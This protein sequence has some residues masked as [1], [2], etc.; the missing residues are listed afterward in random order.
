MKKLFTLLL[1][2][3][4]SLGALAYDNPN[5]FSGVS[6]KDIGSDTQ[7][8][9]ITTAGSLAAWKEADT[10][11]SQQG[12]FNSN[13]ARTKLV[14]TGS[15]T[16]ADFDVITGWNKFTFAD[17]SSV[18]GV[19]P[20]DISG[21]NLSNATTIVLPN[22]WTEEQVKTAGGI[23]TSDGKNGNLGTA[24]SKNPYVKP[25]ST[26][27]YY[28][29]KDGQNVTYNGTVT[30]GQ[31]TVTINEPV[32]IT[33]LTNASGYPKSTYTNT[34]FNNT[35]VEVEPSEG[36]TSWI[37]NPLDVALNA[38]SEYTYN[39][40]VLN[41]PQIVENN[42]NYYMDNNW[43]RWNS[44]LNLG[45]QPDQWGNSV[46]YDQ[47]D[48]HLL[49][50]AKITYNIQNNNQLYGVYVNGV[51]QEGSGPL[52]TSNGTVYGQIANEGEN[53]VSFPI[54]SLYKYTYTLDGNDIETQEFTSAQTQI[55]T[56]HDV[57]Y[58]LLSNEVTE[59]FNLTKIFAYV[60]V[61]GTFDDAVNVA[62]ITKSTVD[63][64]ALI[65]GIN[66]D[67]LA[68]L[69]KNNY[70]NVEY[71][72]MKDAVLTG[73]ITTLNAR[74]EAAIL[75]PQINDN[76]TTRHITDAEL[77]KLQ[78]KNITS[79]NEQYFHCLAYFKS[80]DASK[81]ESKQLN[82][83]AFDNA[84]GK[85]SNVVKA[86][87]NIAITFIPR[88]TEDGDFFNIYGG[89]VRGFVGYQFTSSSDFNSLKEGIGQL[90][91][92]SIDMEIISNNMWPDFTFLNAN[93]HYIQVHGNVNQNNSNKYDNRFDISSESSSRYVYPNTVWVVSTYKVDES[94]AYVLDEN[95]NPVVIGQDPQGKDIW[96]RTGYGTYSH[97][98]GERFFEAQEPTNIVY[99]RDRSKLEGCDE[100]PSLL[101]EAKKYFE[102]DQMFA[103]QQIFIGSYN[104]ADIAAIND[105]FA[106]T[107]IDFVSASSF[108]QVDGKDCVAN[109]TNSKVQYLLLPDNHESVINATSADACAFSTN[110]T[111]LLCVGAYNET[112]NRLTTWSRQA[113][114]VAN[115]TSKL[116][117]K[118]G[119]HHYGTIYDNYCQGL[120]KVT[121]SGVLNR[122][123]L[124]NDKGKGLLGSSIQEA[125]FTNAYFPTYTDMVFSMD[126]TSTVA[127]G[128][129]WGGITKLSLPI[130][131]R[132]DR[133]PAHCLDGAESLSELC[134]PYNF[135]YIEESAFNLM[136]ADKITTTDAEGNVIDNGTNTFTLSANLKDIATLAFNT[137]NSALTDV[138]V[139]ATEAPH[140]APFAFT[141]ENYFC[142][143]GFDGNFK[144]P[145]CRDGYQQSEKFY[146]ILHF[147][148]EIS[149]EEAAHYT[150]ITREYSLVDETSAFD[151]QGELLTWPNHT[152]ICRA[153][154]QALSGAL[155]ND[156][157]Y[158]TEAAFNTT[159]GFLDGIMKMKGYNDEEIAEFKEGLTYANSKKSL[160]G[161]KGE[162]YYDLI[163]TY[164][165]SNSAYANQDNFKIGQL[166]EATDY[167]KNSSSFKNYIGWHQFVLSGYSRKINVT[168]KNKDYKKLDFYTLCFPY[169]L[170]REELINL[171]GV[172]AGNTLNGEPVSE[173][174]VLPEV[175]TLKSVI[176]NQVSHRVDLGFSKE[177]MQIADETGKDIT[178]TTETWDYATSDLKTN[179][180]KKGTDKRIFLKG[181]YPYLVKPYVLADVSL[182]GKNLGEYML[183]ISN[184]TP[185]DLGYKQDNI[186]VPYIQGVW[187][188]D[189]KGNKLT[190]KDAENKS[191]NYYYYFQGTYIRQDLP[192][193]AYYLG[194]KSGQRAW[195][196]NTTGTRKWNQ[197]SA[198]IG[199]KCDEESVVYIG[200]NKGDSADGITTPS[201][202]MRN[203]DDA[204]ENNEV[205]V[206]FLFEDEDG[207]DE[208]VAIE[209]INGEAVN[210]AP[211]QGDVYNMTGQ[212]VGNTVEGLAKGLY[213]INGKKILVK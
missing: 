122:D 41:N 183:S 165:R 119:T 30:A 175:Y 177:L 192:Q 56:N 81:P 90:P 156:W 25:V 111:A 97:F 112:D 203:D 132:Q 210:G 93:T 35:V 76:G 20:A 5:G 185:A 53:A 200:L 63:E 34:W 143:T 77:G 64:I 36:Q 40:T 196:Y 206:N 65:N 194:A 207:F 114:V 176:R 27:T 91:A 50:S 70:A 134:I 117:P 169:D 168:P 140:C 154:N 55:Q 71:I 39:G 10:D 100:V 82:I 12:Y 182:T 96:Q 75:L 195:F 19:V 99:V 11:G 105:D 68:E 66:N 86:E 33:E 170:T 48:E 37:P 184:L 118:V 104:A 125:D 21:L 146:A 113:G 45:Q 52:F 109:L 201:V 159:L 181:G 15:M 1:G 171:I 131:S 42:G 179:N 38:T 150:D 79:P 69:S 46:P 205:K 108:E 212:Y 162:N 197:F 129:G 189:E 107:T 149:D 101:A 54:T 8:I 190:W 43:A 60:N 17:F 78:A 84:V 89:S 198:V 7:L 152:E 51:A 186:S 23:L 163:E 94:R 74:G 32:T 141:T 187:S 102:N 95:G 128:Y 164:D 62:G 4:A 98:G 130:D 103:S 188:K 172:P 178:I 110:C 153:Y 58:D 28:Y 115:L 13:P 26:T 145:I 139:L 31:E 87:D 16:K 157:D 59:N 49:V 148:A 121:M 3:S 22:G 67:D 61:A 29:V 126:A 144:H 147:P 174:G 120:T 166:A 167:A 106:A 47:F 209:S 14:I 18:T 92:I 142:N 161:I 137:K 124:L 199:G 180:N 133:I 72:N 44:G 83:Y 24:F 136:K 193:Y 73:D 88:Y 213:I 191:H 2:L 138:Y 204:F 85:L 123:D 208:V 116:H 173:N 158:Q 57:T 155:W 151:G 127:P 135:Q 9:E 80:N 160:R 202:M 6:F 211:L